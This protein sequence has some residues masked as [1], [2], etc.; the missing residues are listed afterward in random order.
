MKNTQSCP[1]WAL[2]DI[3]LE[4]VS[5]YCA[6]LQRGARKKLKVPS[7]SKLKFVRL[8]DKMPKNIN[9]IV[10]GVLSPVVLMYCVEVLTAENAL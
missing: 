5:C 2:N 7:Q 10:N 8:M 9:K 4:L 1:V 3:Q 6:D